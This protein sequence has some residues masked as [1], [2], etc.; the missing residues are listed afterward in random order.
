MKPESWQTQRRPDGPVGEDGFITW[1]RVIE[2]WERV[3]GVSPG[4]SLRNRGKPGEN[5][6]NFHFPPGPSL[7]SGRFQPGGFCCLPVFSASGA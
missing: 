4:F 6:P 7:R 1:E 5:G 3:E 2:P